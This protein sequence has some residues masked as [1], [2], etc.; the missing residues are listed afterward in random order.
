MRLRFRLRSILRLPLA[1]ARCLEG[2]NTGRTEEGTA[3]ED[4]IDHTDHT[5]SSQW[6]PRAKGTG[7]RPLACELPAS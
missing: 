6:T 2:G 7:K 5:S 4:S 3:L 1:K